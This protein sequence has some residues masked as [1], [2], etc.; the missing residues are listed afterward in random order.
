MGVLQ[1]YV[2]ELDLVTKSV[3]GEV[4]QKTEK[5]VKKLGRGLEQTT[6]T[7]TKYDKKGNEIITTT[8]RINRRM[9]RFQMEQLGVMFG[10]MALNRAMSNLNATSREW[11]GMNELMS[12]AMGLVTLPTTMN[13]LNFGVLPLF[14][15]L[16]NLPE[17]AKQAIGTVS[18]ALE[19]LGGVMMI[20]GQLA[21]GLSSTMIVL[22]KLGG[23]AAAA[24]LGLMGLAGITIVGVGVALGISSLTAE[25]GTTALISALGSGVAIALGAPLLGASATT[26]IALGA[27]TVTGLLL[28]RFSSKMIEEAKLY[29]ELG[30]DINNIEDFISGEAQ[31][32]GAFLGGTRIT[33]APGAGQFTIN[34][35]NTIS[36]V[37]SEKVQ[38]EIDKK[39][40]QTTDEIRR[41]VKT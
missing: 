22:E 20:G 38:R 27:I 40:Q 5:N 37:E 30:K 21:L 9:E 7:L 35:Y 16:T 33:E 6:T 10:G 24:K 26:G 31:Q 32:R 2:I 25:D 3:G 12:T 34:Q 41:I 23:A 18:L 8:D 36:G 39:F 13:L 4:I 11:V 28:W 1:N 17:P 14:D 15:A 29:D 19:G